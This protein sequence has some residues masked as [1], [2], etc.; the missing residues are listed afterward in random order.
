MDASDPVVV[1]ESLMMVA[2]AMDVVSVSVME[3]LVAL[4]MVA[5]LAMDVSEMDVVMD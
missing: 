4:V 1:L 3:G 5:V 2:S